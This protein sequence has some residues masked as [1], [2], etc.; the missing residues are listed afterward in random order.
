[1]AGRF[2]GYLALSILAT[3]ANEPATEA[4][5]PPAV[6]TIVSDVPPVPEPDPTPRV[7][8]GTVDPFDTDEGRFEIGGFIKRPPPPP[9]V[10]A[11]PE[12]EQ[13]P[14][15]LVWGPHA[16]APWKRTGLIASAAISGV[17]VVGAIVT[18]P[19]AQRRLLRVETRIADLQRRGYSVSGHPRDA[20]RDIELGLQPDRVAVSD[21]NLAHRCRSF[22][23][24]RA[25]HGLSIGVA[26][27]GAVSAVTFAI[28]HRV[29][30]SD[31]PRR[32]EARSD[33]FALR[34]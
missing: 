24:M 3:L 14:G 26:V 30:R 25:V 11:E 33:G 8:S 29:H 32:V 4:P 5:L 27:A 19:I 10:L 6:P 21:V 20:C 28:L 16:V 17:G 31:Q 22:K 18:W 13:H 9:P 1:M 7:R 12:S 23:R 15:E 34:F 2:M